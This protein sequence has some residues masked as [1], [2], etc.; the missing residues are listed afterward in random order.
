MAQIYTFTR[1][2]NAGHTLLGNVGEP[3]LDLWWQPAFHPVISDLQ[4]VF[5]LFP[6][7]VRIFKTID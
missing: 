1:I 3:N 7:V 5:M 4:N 2:A 6:F